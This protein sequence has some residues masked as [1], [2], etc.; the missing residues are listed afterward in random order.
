MLKATRR[1]RW[2]D[3]VVAIIFFSARRCQNGIMGIFYDLVSVHL[4]VCLSQ[5]R[6]L[7]K[8]TLKLD[9]SSRFWHGVCTCYRSVSRELEYLRKK[10]TSLTNSYFSRFYTFCHRALFVASAVNSV[11]PATV[12]N[13]SHWA[14][15]FVYSLMGATPDTFF[16]RWYHYDDEVLPT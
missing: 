6:V 15:T 8:H 11:W 3:N 1:R 12:T 5:V 13:L 9:G 7:S 14:S 2:R 10:G 4:L 16:R